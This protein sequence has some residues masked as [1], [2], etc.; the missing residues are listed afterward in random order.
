MNQKTQSSAATPCDKSRPLKQ[1]TLTDKQRK[2][3][4][5]SRD[6]ESD[7]AIALELGVHIGTVRL[8]RSALRQGIAKGAYSD[9]GDLA[10]SRTGDLFEAAA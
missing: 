10:K 6:G 8:K 1:R 3:L 5:M 2:L 4:E 7:F 9:I